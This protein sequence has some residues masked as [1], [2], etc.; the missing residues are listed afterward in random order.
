MKIL[1]AGIGNIF[2]GDDAFGCEVIRELAD[3]GLP[4]SVTV[5]DFG[6]GSYDLAFALTEDFDAV[7]LADAAPRG[8]DPGTLYL[9]EPNA[10]GLIEA[11]PRS[12]DGHAMGP[13]AVIQMARSIGTVCGRLFLVGCEPETC[14]KEEGQMGLSASVQEAIPQALAMI[15]SLVADLLRGKKQNERVAGLVRA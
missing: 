9:I 10:D 7:I 3:R 14:G 4:E 15:E 1:V 2:F 13:V 6:I 8:G 12:L 11:G 5:K